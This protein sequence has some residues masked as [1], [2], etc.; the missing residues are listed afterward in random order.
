MFAVLG[1]IA[2]LPIVYPIISV[3]D[4]IC[5]LVQ[6]LLETSPSMFDNERVTKWLGFFMHSLKTEVSEHILPI[7][8]ITH[9]TYHP[10][11]S[12]NMQD[13]ISGQSNSVLF[14]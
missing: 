10:S 3:I 14:M 8:R 4:A 9:H 6:T 12:R 2:I 7:T 1:N 11:L 13:I 5:G